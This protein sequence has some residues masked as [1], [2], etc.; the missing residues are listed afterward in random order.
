VYS[1]HQDRIIRTQNEK[2]ELVISQEEL[3][4][5]PVLQNN[6]DLVNFLQNSP[7]SIQNLQFSHDHRFIAISFPTVH[8][9]GLIVKDMNTG[10]T[11]FFVENIDSFV[12]FD[13]LY[14]LFYV[15]KD[16]DTGKGRKV[17]RKDFGKEKTEDEKILEDTRLNIAGEPSVFSELIYEEAD[18]SYSVEV[19]QSLSSEY[20]LLKSDNLSF[21]PLRIATEFRFRASN[22]SEGNFLIIQERK[23]G[24]NY[25]VKHQGQ[26]FYLLVSSPE[27][28]N[29]K[30]LRLEIPP[31]SSYVPPEG[32]IVYADT[33]DLQSD[34]LGAQV[35]R[36]HSAQVYIEHIEAYKD[37]LISILIDTENSMQHI[38]VDNFSTGSTDIVAYDKYEGA[39][40]VANNKSYRIKLD[41]TEQD[42]YSGS[43]N[44]VLSTLH[45]P[46]QQIG[47]DLHTRANEVLR[48]V[49]DV[50][51]VRLQDYTSERI[52]LPANDGV[53]I[54][55]TLI[56]HKKNVKT[57]DKAA[58]II[59]SY[60]GD[61]E[62]SHNF[63][64]NYSWFS[65]LDR[66]FIWAIPHVRG[67]FDVNR[68][69]YDQ[70]TGVNKI[71]H[72]QD[73]LDVIVSLFSEKIVSSASGYSV[74]PS[75]GLAF[76]ALFLREPE[77]LSC[78]V[79]RVMII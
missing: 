31:L 64:L 25:E 57:G 22:R 42:Y 29:G 16:R 5:H 48:T 62:N 45:S 54:P 72:F 41:Q 51:G 6:K 38:Q 40:K 7:F 19:L 43:F 70:G 76:A 65:I 32:P 36:P 8:S 20:V 10:M 77:L 49:Y 56:Y 1:H 18:R 79:L 71:R 63:Q 23:E 75:G 78:A 66:G 59:E 67:S 46:D 53:L 17:W 47:Y 69:W 60:G 34:F 27:E 61:I 26:Y 15:E 44:Y 39:L 12:V 4:T 73:L 14:G 33:K 28:Y 11:G 13:N 35:F 24:R 21:D 3:I 74:V 9:L 55:V 52:V 58:A 37:H 30:V 68:T 2:E 50:P